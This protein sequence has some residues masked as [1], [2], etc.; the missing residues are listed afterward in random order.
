MDFLRGFS[1]AGQEGTLGPTGSYSRS[2]LFGLLYFCAYIAA[3]WLL[4]V[5]PALSL[6]ITPWNAGAG[7]SLALLIAGG[8]HTLPIVVMAV[9]TAEIGSHVVQVPAPVVILGCI[10]IALV[11][12]LLAW[13][14]KTRITMESGWTTPEVARFAGSCTVAALLAATGFIGVF[15]FAGILDQADIPYAVARFALADLNGMLMVT[16]LLLLAVQNRRSARVSGRQLLKL[17]PIP[18]AMLL[19]L[20]VLFALPAADQLRFFYFLFAPV[21]WIAL[22]W[23]LAGAVF[24]V[25]TA[26]VALLAAAKLQIHTPRFIDL[27]TLM[28]TLTL[29]ALLLGAVVRDRRRSEDQLREKDAILARAMRFAVAGELAS[30]LAHELKQPM[31]ALA[32]YLQA[33]RILAA[34]TAPADERLIA[35][36]DKASA[37]AMRSAA[38]LSRLR[39]FYV[40]GERK[41]ERIRLPELCT[42]V[43]GAFQERLRAC[44][45]SLALQ[46]DTEIPDF[47]GDSLQLEIVLHNLVSNAIDAVSRQGVVTRQ[48]LLRVQHSANLVTLAVEDSGRGVDPDIAQRLFEPFVTDSTGGM[49]LGLAISQSLVRAAG[50]ELQ[51]VPGSGLG[52]ACFM[53]RMP[54]GPDASG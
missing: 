3:D 7:L 27:Q 53:I 32:S 10:W 49:G 28:L 41:R 11:Y 6:G 29:T 19:T 31:T 16:P 22:R 34:R 51:M 48:I 36:L 1:F 13:I 47:E 26:Q 38:V 21:I 14:L 8:I 44:H 35:T 40:G 39:D 17:L 50:G 5:R 30:V 52:G 33:G 4:G 43:A 9:I 54:L 18:A 25:L 45:A 42:Q 23:S 2:A 46:I 37:E 12:G 24:A 20:L 15:A